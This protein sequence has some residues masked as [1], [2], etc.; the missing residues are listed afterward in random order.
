MRAKNSQRPSSV[1]TELIIVTP[2]Q[3]WLSRP[4]EARVVAL[5]NATVLRSDGAAFSHRRLWPRQ[6]RARL[7]TISEEAV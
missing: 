7:Y 2:I 1:T 6:D 4:S 5:I 3:S